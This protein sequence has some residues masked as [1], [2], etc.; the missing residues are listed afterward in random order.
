MPR[1]ILILLFAFAVP[2]LMGVT[3]TGKYIVSFSVFGKIGEADVSM[4]EMGGRYHIHVDGYLTGMA[5][6]LGAHRHETHDS[7]GTVHEGVYLPDRYVKDRRSDTRDE[8]TVYT[9]D[10]KAKTVTKERTKRYVRNGSRFDPAQMKIVDVSEDVKEHAVQ[11]VPYYAPND[12]LSLFFNVKNFL[13]EIPRGGQSVQHSVGATN[14]KGEVLITNPNG[15]KRRA[16][17]RLMP[18]NDDRLITVVVDEDIFESEKGELYLNLDDNY[19]AIEA[20]LKDVLLFGDIRAK[21]IAL[22]RAP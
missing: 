22:K 3:L 15:E 6:A 20:M 9:F 17:A 2:G 13:K 1:I 7:Y 11:A 19:L 8:T 12:L 21:R 10:H 5:A 4:E 14:K 18:D 16:L